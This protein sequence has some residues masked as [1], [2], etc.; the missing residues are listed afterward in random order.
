VVDDRT[1]EELMD[2]IAASIACE[3]KTKMASTP[4][5]TTSS[6]WELLADEIDSR[7]A[8]F[9]ASISEASAKHAYDDG[10]TCESAQEVADLKKDLRAD[11]R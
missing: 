7:L 10:P 5:L 1:P 8:K 9:H 11:K 6:A 3:E 4:C 2:I